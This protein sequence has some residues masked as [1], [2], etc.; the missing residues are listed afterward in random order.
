[1]GIFEDILKKRGLNPD[2]L[3]DFICPKYEKL[4][5]PFLLP[6]M[7]KAV[8]RLASAHKNKEQVTIYGDYDI[9]GLTA[10]ALL[11]DALKAFG[12]E[13]VKSFIPNRFVEGYGLTVEAIEEIAKTKTDLIITVDCG[14]LSFEPIKRAKSLGMDVIV[15]DHHNVAD[16]QP[17]AVAVINPKRKGHKYPFKELAGVGVAFKLIQAMQTKLEGLPAGQEKWLLDLV[18]LGTVCDVVPLLGENRTLVHYGLKVLNQTRR[19][20]LVALSEVAGIDYQKITTRDLGFGLGP[21]L[22]AAGRLETA[23]YSLELLTATGRE[24]AERYAKL[25]DEMNKDRRLA[26]NLIFEEAAEMAAKDNSDVLVLSSPNWNHGIVG[27]VAARILEEF[28]KPTFVMQELDDTIKGS[29]RS[30]GDFS[31]AEAIKEAQDIIIKGGGH[32]LAAGVTL[33]IGS[34]DKFRSRVN[35]YYASLKLKNQLDYLVPAADSEAAG[36]SELTLDLLDQIKLL[37][38][39]GNGNPEPIIKLTSDKVAVKFMGSELQHVKLT[40]TDESGD[41]SL[42]KFYASDDYKELGDKTIEVLFQPTVNEWN[43]Q[44]TV[45]G[46]IVHLKLA[47]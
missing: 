1:M 16:K 15:T 41:I 45:E 17:E 10:T 37:E 14:S 29:A 47:S 22:N 39:F 9:D 44:K 35:E 34:V 20:G 3:D 6:D 36:T 11:M 25:L 7:Q 46:K 8:D 21:R 23:Q 24:N 5:D 31:V 28:K 40:V 43:G 42:I 12:F 18:A 30:Y 27:I 13:N 19:V 26:Q 32:N 33:P 38:P 2:N 4:H